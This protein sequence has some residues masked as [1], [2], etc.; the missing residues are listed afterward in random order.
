LLLVCHFVPFQIVGQTNNNQ[1]AKELAQRSLKIQ[2]RNFAFEKNVGQ[3]EGNHLYLA[4]DVQAD[5]F[6]LSDE[7]RTTVKNGSGSQ[8]LSYGMRFVN[9]NPGSAPYGIGRADSEVGKLNY[10]QGDKMLAEIPQHDMLRYSNLWNNIHAVFDNSPE[11]LKYDFIVM[12]GGNPADVQLEMFG[13]SNL[14]VTPEGELSFNTPFGTLVKGKP[15]TYQVIKNQRVEVT[16]AYKVEGNRISFEV[17]NYDKNYNLVIDPVA[18][19]WAT[20]LGGNTAF[21]ITD[22]HFDVASGNLYAT[23]EEWGVVYPSTYG[24]PSQVG[25]TRN[26]FVMCMKGDGS[27]ILWKTRIGRSNGQIVTGMGINVDAQG[28]VHAVLE[29]NG[30]EPFAGINPEVPGIVMSIPNNMGSWIAA[31]IKLNPT[32]DGIKYFTYLIDP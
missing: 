27:E 21:G 17:G 16:A 4:R 9:A 25:Q 2:S 24:F 8:E 15:V 20:I 11:G 23:G 3:M 6:F 18:L 29:T 13:V 10:L 28:N 31:L 30:H 22:A 7:V 26:A 32:G 5:Y 12:P 14:K 1:Q 19:K